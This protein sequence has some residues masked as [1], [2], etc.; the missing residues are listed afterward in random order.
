MTIRSVSARRLAP[1]GLGCLLAAVD[2]GSATAQINTGQ[3]ASRLPFVTCN[4]RV[5]FRTAEVKQ[6]G[7]D[8]NADGDFLD[9]D[10]QVLDL[11]TG[12]VTNVAIDASGALACGGNLFAFGVG[13]RAQGNADLNG[14]LDVTDSV[15]HVYDAVA[16]T[17]TNVGLPVTSVVASA[18]LVAFTVPEAGQGA[19]GTDLNGDG[20]KTDLVLGVYDPATG[21]A[22]NVGQEAGDGTNIKVVG[23]T[24]AF[25]TSEQAQGNTDL[26]GD[27]DAID[28]VL[29]IYDASTGVLTNTGRQAQ[30]KPGIQFD[31]PV[32]AFLVSEA[33]QG[34]LPL[35]PDIDF[36]DLVLHL[37]CLSSPPCT[38]TGVI[39]LGVD[40]SGGFTLA[41]D[42][43]AFGMRE[44]NQA[45][46]NL[47]PPDADTSDV[48]AQVYRISTN[49][50]TNTGLA[51]RGHMR[52]AGNFVAI[53]V[54]ER[55]QN[56]TDLNGDGDAKDSVMHVYDAAHGTV[57]NL[58]RAVW[59]RGC[60]REG[61]QP[62][63]KGP[64]SAMA[65]DLLMFATG[66]YDQGATDL[67]GDGDIKDAVVQTWKLSTG[68]LINT[69][70]AAD[71]RSPLIA[72]GSIGVFRV[73]ERSQ[74]GANLNGDLDA[75]DSVMAVFDVT[76]GSTTL[77]G[78]QAQPLFLLEGTTVVFRTGEKEQTADLNLDGDRTDSVLQ[79]RTF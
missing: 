31:G 28:T 24:V 5:G 54:P 53:V 35:N 27:G 15:L 10:F 66:E 75:A 72:A 41:G 76:T 71:L 39:N 60:P 52:V 22:T 68:T 65:G 36:S 77:I 58:G 16:G 18:N 7:T 61:A 42:L 45:N 78:Q 43:I 51:L 38:S 3:D 79:Y 64:C 11:G 1:L 50:R 55:S 17:V 73:S 34:P 4:G 40:A 56:N 30:K 23:T 49:T 14:D 44:H 63:P 37:Y 48:V 6:G 46:I 9:F 20:D 33:R 21:L 59:F 13:E 19:G 32:V 47:N 29:Q 25:L 8:L 62:N 57:T 12:A 69:G 70:L 74:G 2:L 26:N 67:N